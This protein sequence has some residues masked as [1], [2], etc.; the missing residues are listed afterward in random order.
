MKISSRLLDPERRKG[1]LFPRG[2][3]RTIMTVVNV[4]GSMC[5][6]SSD[7]ERE[8]VLL[9]LAVLV[10]IWLQTSEDDSSIEMLNYETH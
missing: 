1:S 3:K 8:K 2:W 5:N 7:Q 4:S 6:G 10:S 9:D